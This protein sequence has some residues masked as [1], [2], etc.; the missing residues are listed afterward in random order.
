MTTAMRVFVAS[1]GFA[2]LI[3]CSPPPETDE[4]LS[5]DPATKTGGCKTSKSVY[6]A[7]TQPI[8]TLESVN[9]VPFVSRVVKLKWGGCM[10]ITFSAEGFTDDLGTGGER[11]LRINARVTHGDGSTTEVYPLPINEDLGYSFVNTTDNSFENHTI[12]WTAEGKRGGS[13][14]EI[15]YKTGQAGHRSSIRAFHLAIEY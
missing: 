11:I 1:I 15:L 12:A 7:H 5:A 4:T 8:S 2:L 6:V 10:H 13:K 14:V 9:F 3:G